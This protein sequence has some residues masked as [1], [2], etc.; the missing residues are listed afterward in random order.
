MPDIDATYKVCALLG[1]PAHHSLGPAMHNAAFAALGLPLV[2]VAHDVAPADLAA[3]L[4]GARALGYLGLS[5]TMP[6]KVAALSLVDEVDPMARAIGCI[7][8][9]VNHGGRL[10][11]SNSDGQGALDALTRAGISTRNQRVLVLGSGGAARAVAMT[12]A[13]R[14]QPAEMEI[15]GIVADELHRLC[16][17]VAAETRSP[18]TGGLLD[19][20]RLAAAAARAG[21]TGAAAARTRGLRRRVQAAPDQ[22]H[23][24]GRAARLPRGRRHGDV[25]RPGHAAVRAVDGQTGARRGDAPGA[26]GAAVNLVLVGYRGTGKSALARRLATLLGRRTVSLDDEI[27]R[28]A[29]KSIPAIVSAEGWSHFRDLEEAVCRKFAAEDGLRGNGRVFW[30]RASPA[31]IVGRIGKDRSRPSLTG[32]RSFTEEVEEVLER[33]TPLYQRICHDVIDTDGRHLD[34]LAAT[35]ASRFQAAASRS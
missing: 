24:P 22:A 32:R 17:D 28:A 6:H 15:L 33:R 27:V 10:V 21:P 26:R 12:V 23:R 2:Y 20:A 5:L 3:A 11:G 35:I 25:P 18:V 16:A 30:L 1:F 29:G 8:T 13:M 19:D 9:V 34:E 4:A 14:G 31:T 7:N